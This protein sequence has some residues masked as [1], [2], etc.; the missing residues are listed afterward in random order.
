MNIKAAA[1]KYVIEPASIPAIPIAGTDQFFPVH[2]VYC[3]GQE[4]VGF[5]IGSRERARIAPQTGQVAD[6]VQARSAATLTWRRARR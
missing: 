3:V 4:V 1:S 5:R 6:E 2:R